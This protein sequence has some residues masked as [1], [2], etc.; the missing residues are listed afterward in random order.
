MLSINGTKTLKINKIPLIF[1]SEYDHKEVQVRPILE[2]IEQKGEKIDGK[3]TYLAKGDEVQT[4]IG[5]Y[6]S[7][8]GPFCEDFCIKLSDMEETREKY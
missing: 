6:N 5:I 7:L 4:L 3:I 1:N 2:H 8:K